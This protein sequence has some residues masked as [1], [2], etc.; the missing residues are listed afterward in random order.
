MIRRSGAAR[1]RR[2]S[3]RGGF[4]LV[5]LMVAMLVL[6]VGILGLASTAG[7]VTRMMSGGVRQ[8]IA[9]SVVQ[10]R[11]ELLRN[12]PC[13][14]LFSGSDTTRGIREKWTVLAAGRNF[15]QVVD[16]VVFASTSGRL[17]VARGY[18]SYVPCR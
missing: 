17:P 11:F 14:S 2:R 4:T 1:R 13:A 16:T 7:V 9:S 15:R 8:T 10:T 6:T 5:E 3:R 12:Q 18:R